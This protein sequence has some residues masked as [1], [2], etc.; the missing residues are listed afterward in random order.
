MKRLL[1]GFQLLLLCMFSIHTKVE[2]GQ[3]LVNHVGYE[4]NGSKNAVF[5]LSGWEVP[6]V[7]ELLND[8]GKVVYS[9]KFEKGGKVDNWHTGNAYAANFSEFKTVGTFKLSTTINAKIWES[10][11]IVIGHQ[12]VA[13]QTLETL[14]QGI[15]SQRSAGEFD[16]KDKKMS[17]HG[18]RNDTVDVHGG[19][20]DA[21]GDR[22]KYLSHLSYANYMN[23][24]QAPMVVWNFLA[25]SKAFENYLGDNTK[26]LGRNVI[27]EAIHGADWLVR[28]YD[29][30][31]YFYLNVFDNWS[32]DVNKR[33]ICAYVGIEGFK[34]DLYKAGYRMGGGMSIAALAR[35]SSQ[36]LS[37]AF[38]ATD[39]LRTAQKTF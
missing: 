12:V 13:Q 26:S 35:A 33:S 7:F 31:G 6:S 14:L 1:F 2:A 4:M 3:W 19:W 37:G 34:N 30:E 36:G 15:H 21:S 8:A 5:Q 38:S 16:E 18:Q 39:Y 20:Y 17:F 27:E 24:Q 22:S 25:T 9:S 11:A 32:W 28:M 29:K 23:P 10:D